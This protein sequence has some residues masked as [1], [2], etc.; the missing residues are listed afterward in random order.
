MRIRFG[1]FLW[2]TLVLLAVEGGG[3]RMERG[4]REVDREGGGPRFLPAVAGKNITH[5]RF[6]A[7]RDETFPVQKGR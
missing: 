6:S 3:W 5:G 4:G 2:V 7:C 1:W